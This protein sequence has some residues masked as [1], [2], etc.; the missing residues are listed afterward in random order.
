MPATG[1]VDSVTMSD[2]CIRTPDRPSAPM[3]M[4]GPRRKRSPCTI[5]RTC[6]HAAMLRRTSYAPS[7]TAPQTAPHGS[8]IL[9]AG[10]PPCAGRRY[11]RATCSGVNNYETHIV[12][13]MVMI[14]SSFAPSAS[15]CDSTMPHADGSPA[16]RAR[17]GS[18][19][20]REARRGRD[21]PGASGAR[22]KRCEDRSC[23]L[24][25]FSVYKLR[26]MCHVVFS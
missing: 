12:W 6:R 4:F 17:D 15:S 9:S 5:M 13:T 23:K 24:A 3:C 20:R 21:P 16:E 2:Y 25:T 10:P 26:L 1:F 8:W 14:H 19:A 18:D 22:D 7:P 11:R